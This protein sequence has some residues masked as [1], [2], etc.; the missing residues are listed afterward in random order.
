MENKSL[1]ERLRLQAYHLW[2]ADG[3]P[4]GRSDE[5][6]QRAREL[7]ERETSA[8]SASGAPAKKTTRT[9]LNAAPVNTDHVD[10]PKAKPKAASKPVAKKAAKPKAADAAEK[11]PKAVAEAP[12]KPA[13]KAA[14]K[15]KTAAD[16]K[17][18][19]KAAPKPAAKATKAAAKAPKK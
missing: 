6:W 4:H 19:G 8:D 15:P 10:A 17:P 3:R 16:A 12:A 9:K 11:K 7:L 18:S 2:E 1:E 14:A 5:Y 13:K